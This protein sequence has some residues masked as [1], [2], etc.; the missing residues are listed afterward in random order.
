MLYYRERG[1]AQVLESKVM[2]GE[3]LHRFGPPQP[4]NAACSTRCVE[5][6]I[7]HCIIS[8]RMVET[9]P[10]N[11]FSFFNLDF[12]IKVLAFSGQHP[13]GKI[14]YQLS[15]E[16]KY[17]W[18]QWWREE[19]GSQRVAGQKSQVTLI[20]RAVLQGAP[21]RSHSP[22]SPEPPKKAV[23]QFCTSSPHAFVLCLYIEMAD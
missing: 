15:I 4:E 21:L 7:H 6:R 13:R 16:A 11:P 17:L 12:Q 2:S 3:R 19:N 5:M 8:A 22:V 18:L 20:F 1:K 23:A 14:S 10:F 9:F